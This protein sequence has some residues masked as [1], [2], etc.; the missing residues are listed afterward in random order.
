MVQLS[1]QFTNTHTCPKCNHDDFKRKYIK[2]PAKGDTLSAE[3][4]QYRCT[5]CGYIFRTLCADAKR[6]G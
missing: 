1:V 2:V 6:Q 5:G 3:L 4:M